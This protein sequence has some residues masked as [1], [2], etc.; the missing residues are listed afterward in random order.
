MG[1][2]L[3]TEIKDAWAQ[4]NAT[5]RNDDKALVRELHIKAKAIAPP[6]KPTELISLFERKRNLFKPG[7]KINP[8]KIEPVLHLVEPRTE[9]EQI[10]K[11]CRG[12][13]SMPYSYG[14]GRRL[15]FVL[16][17]Q[18]H[19]SVMG[20]IGLQSPPADL[21]CRDALFTYPKGEKLD[22]VNG[23]LEAYTVGAVPP[24]SQLLGGKLAGSLIVSDSIRQAYW[25][26][27]AGKKT[28]MEKKR[29]LQ[30]LLA[31]TTASAFGR[32]SIYNRMNYG[33]RRIAEPIGYT[34]G[35]G[36]IHL[37]AIYPKLVDWLKKQGVLVPSGFGNGPKVRW[38]NI[39]IGLQMLGLPNEYAIH[40]LRR[41]VFLFRHVS[42]LEAVCAGKEMPMPIVLPAKDLFEYWKE[43][44]AIPRSLRDESW[45]HAN[46]FSV[47]LSGLKQLLPN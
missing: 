19:E 33:D 11:I 47:M 9:W 41:E 30:P 28:I 20:I 24:Y 6:V 35:F 37:E 14:Y 12:Y 23:M 34:K 42:N 18:H 4:F 25:R 32:S 40:G 16:F 8:A 29:L 43:R 7:S 22:Y 36:T 21:A 1:E 44:W 26:Q 31:V 27:Y 39:T 13:W 17:D 45:R 46:T 38:Q 3:R 5:I 2:Y 15:R 10:F